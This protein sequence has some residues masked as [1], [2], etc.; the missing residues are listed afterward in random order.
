MWICENPVSQ[1]HNRW[2]IFTS[3][4]RMFTFDISYCES[5]KR[6]T[7]VL[8]DEY[9]NI[10]PNMISV[11]RPQ[12][13]IYKISQKCLNR[14]GFLKNYMCLNLMVVFSILYVWISW[15]IPKCFQ[16]PVVFCT[17]SWYMCACISMIR[18]VVAEFSPMVFRV[19]RRCGFLRSIRDGSP[20]KSKTSSHPTQNQLTEH[21]CKHTG[22]YF[23]EIRY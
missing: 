21:H 8:S 17:R 5:V 7:R 6:C 16:V 20:R 19:D 1:F 9:S 14:L 23:L 15:F 4:T 12:I 13:R 2:S 22:F 18:F 10:I 3:W 11:F